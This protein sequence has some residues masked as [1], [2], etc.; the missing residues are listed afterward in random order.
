MMVAFVCLRA[1]NHDNL[2]SISKFVVVGCM[3][4]T[5][6]SFEILLPI[7]VSYYPD[8][9]RSPMLRLDAFAPEHKLAMNYPCVGRYGFTVVLMI[10]NE[11]CEWFV[12]EPDWNHKIVHVH[13][14]KCNVEVNLIQK[15]APPISYWNS[16][17]RYN[18][19]YVSKG[20]DCSC[21]RALVPLD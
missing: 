13:K 15:H 10:S 19:V 20:G 3:M 5:I 21:E 1:S 18:C 2:V 11:N 8:C 4:L 17:I 7:L 6:S 12:S 9:M 16:E 14:M